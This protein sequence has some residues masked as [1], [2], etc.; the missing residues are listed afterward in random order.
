MALKYSL[1]NDVP[2]TIRHAE[3]RD[4]KS[5]I[6]VLTQASKESDYLTYGPRDL[7][8]ILEKEGIQ[9]REFKIDDVYYDFIMMG[10][11]IS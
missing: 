11:I 6:D 8:P 3:V 2:D 1:K 9:R 10:K 7:L 4:A 5:L